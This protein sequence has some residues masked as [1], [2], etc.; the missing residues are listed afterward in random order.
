MTAGHENRFSFCFRL[1]GN[2]DCSGSKQT[3]G[4]T[5]GQTITSAYHSSHCLS[6]DSYSS[7]YATADKCTESNSIT[8]PNSGTNT[9]ANK[10]S[11]PF[12][13]SSSHRGSQPETFK[14]ANSK[15]YGETFRRANSEA[16]S[17]PNSTSNLWTY[18]D[19][20]GFAE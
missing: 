19:S 16:Y 11:I 7:S 13:Y 9:V 18:C 2:K 5:H 14:F 8:S 15:A 20:Y 17:S 1:L 6:V 12:A 3:Y 10:T 4:K